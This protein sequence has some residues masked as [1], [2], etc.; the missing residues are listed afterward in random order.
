MRDPALAAAKGDIRQQAIKGGEVQI[1]ELPNMDP[2]AI[3]NSDCPS[4]RFGPCPDNLFASVGGTG[5][6]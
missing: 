2:Q 3:M 4:E 6:R 5:G 1:S